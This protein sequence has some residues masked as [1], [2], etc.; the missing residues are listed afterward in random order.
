MKRAAIYIIG[1]FRNFNETWAQYSKIFANSSD[2]TFDIF[3]TFWDVRNTK[4]QTSITESD[5][6]AVCPDAK[7]VQ[8]LSSKQPLERHGHTENMTGY[9][10]A[11]QEGVRIL[12]P[13]YD[14]YI[15]LRSDLYFFDTDFMSQVLSSQDYADLWIPDKVWYSSPNYPG[16]DVFNDYLWIGTHAI[17]T[18]LAETYAVLSSLEPTYM[19]QLLARRVQMY[20]SS[21]KIKHF[22]CLFNLDRRTRGED[23]FLQ[24][25]IELTNL[26]QRL[27]DARR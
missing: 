19:E 24:E 22:S 5:V 13:S 26:R 1:H 8:I 2:V 17:T 18:Y 15:R 9:L 6:R 12:P 20:P 14:W 3:I 16:R 4:D 7:H 21:L 27:I 11:L 10:Y 25:S 23:M